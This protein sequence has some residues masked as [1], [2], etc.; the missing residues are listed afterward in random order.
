VLRAQGGLR[1]RL[2]AALIA[3]ATACALAAMP[4]SATSQFGDEPS[5]EVVEEGPPGPPGNILRLN[6]TGSGSL[7]VERVGDRIRL[8]EVGIDL[9]REVICAGGPATVHNIDEIELVQ[10][11]S[12]S[13]PEFFEGELMVDLQDGLLAPGATPEAD[14]SEIELSM[15]SKDRVPFLIFSLVTTHGPD[16]IT[17]VTSIREGTE[18]NLNAGEATDDVDLDLPAIIFSSVYLGSGDDVVRAK[19]GFKALDRFAVGL[20]FEGE[21]GDDRIRASLASGGKGDDELIGGRRTNVFLGGEGH[22]LLRGKNG[23]DILVTETGRDRLF[24]GGGDDLLVAADNNGDRAH[25]GGNRDR[26]V[27]DRRDKR[28][29]CERAKLLNV[30]R[31][32]RVIKVITKRV[33]NFIRTRSGNPFP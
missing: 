20:A 21:R 11:S 28:S 13:F 17:A 27:I 5:C 31:E 2:R 30:K 1:G 16:E 23:R 33:R 8:N 12:G 25:C 3:L 7:E 32:D 10:P 24:G 18:L 6:A 22:D 19:N 14:G 15:P 9:H 26:A 4:S 29:G